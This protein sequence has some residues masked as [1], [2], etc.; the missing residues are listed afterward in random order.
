MNRIETI[1]WTA[2]LTAL[3][4]TAELH[5]QEPVTSAHQDHQE[6]RHDILEGTEK[7]GRIPKSKRPDDL[8]HPNR[9]RYVPEGRLMDGNIFDRFLVSSFISLLPRRAGE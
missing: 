2:L 5:A 7:N 9:W 4:C 8:P 6:K 1:A 3:S